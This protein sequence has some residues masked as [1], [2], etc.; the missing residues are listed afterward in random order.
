MRL[1]SLEVNKESG[2]SQKRAIAVGRTTSV[3]VYVHARDVW[4]RPAAVLLLRTPVTCT[5]TGP[6]PLRCQTPALQQAR[7]LSSWNSGKYINHSVA[8]TAWPP[9]FHQAL[10]R[11]P[12]FLDVPGTK[13]SAA[14]T[15]KSMEYICK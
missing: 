11:R 14:G 4:Q 10:S 7:I 1:V 15:A 2:L 13:E 8:A 5:S 9:Q 3:T 12:A 6:N